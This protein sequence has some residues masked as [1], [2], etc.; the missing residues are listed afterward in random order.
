[1]AADRSDG[2]ALAIGREG[3]AAVGP[4]VDEPAVGEPLDRGR[5]GAGAQPEALG[6]GAGM[7]AA[8]ARQAVD[9]FES[10]AIRF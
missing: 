9:G 3:D 6:Q 10:L 5:D 7:G 1:V 4:V 2:R 8:V